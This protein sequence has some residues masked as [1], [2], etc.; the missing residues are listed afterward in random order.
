MSWRSE[1]RSYVD[2]TI[3]NENNN[4]NNNQQHNQQRDG[5][6]GTAAKYKK[7]GDLVMGGAYKDPVDGALVVFNSKEAAEN[8]VKEDPYV[9]N[10]IVTNFTVREW[11]T[12]KV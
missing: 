7:S 4:N 5:H 11:T 3:T 6:L 12:V 10:G 9:Q 8:F 1:D 2:V